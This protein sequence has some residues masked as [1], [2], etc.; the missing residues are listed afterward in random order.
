MNW[1]RLT[2]DHQGILNLAEASNMSEL[3]HESSCL[4]HF[5]LGHYDK[6]LSDAM[7]LNNQFPS[8]QYFIAM[9]LTALRCLDDPRYGQLVNY[10]AMLYEVDLKDLDAGI[11]GAIDWTALAGEVAALHKCRTRPCCNQLG[12]VPNRLGICLPQIGRAQLCSWAV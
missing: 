12:L 4:A 5:A 8:D 6:A 10:D 3:H 11:G 1:L 9:L 2:G 7:A